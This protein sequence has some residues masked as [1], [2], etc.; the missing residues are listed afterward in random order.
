[1]KRPVFI[2]CTFLSISTLSFMILTTEWYKEDY[3][4][5]VSSSLKQ[6]QN[7]RALVNM[8]IKLSVP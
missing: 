3:A 8:V 7:G 1:V 2:Y 6:C 4:E 5:S